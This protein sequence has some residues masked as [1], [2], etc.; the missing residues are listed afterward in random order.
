[1]RIHL[2]IPGI[3]NPFA[4]RVW[5]FID[6]TGASYM[7]LFAC[8]IAELEKAAEV[9]IQA[10][11]HER[12]ATANGNVSLPAYHLQAR[13]LGN[14]D[15]LQLIAWT[16][17]KVWI[18]SGEPSDSIMRLSGIWPRHLLYF[19]NVPDNQG[20]VYMYDNKSELVEAMPDVDASQAIP[21]RWDF[22][23]HP[24]DEGEMDLTAG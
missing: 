18:S 12:V 14:N 19:T 13:L 24:V 10:F 4:T 23:E 21:P 16:D 6:D 11:G 22:I 8:D 3:T 9:R 20:K 17:I 7:G 15:T 5:D 2:R 1:M